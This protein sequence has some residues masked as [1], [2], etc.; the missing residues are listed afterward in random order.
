MAPGAATP[1]HHHDCDEVVLCVGGRGEVHID[2]QSHRFGPD[3]VIVLPKGVPHQIFNTSTEP[4]ET[5]GILAS[6]PVGTFL[7][8]GSALPLPWRS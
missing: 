1:P 8:D 7:P 3:G 6:S 5:I 4:L 2:G